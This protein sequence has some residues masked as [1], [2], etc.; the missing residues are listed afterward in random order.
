MKYDCPGELD[1]RRRVCDD[2]DGRFDNLSGSH[3]RSQV[4]CESSVDVKVYGCSPDWSTKPGVKTVI[5][6][7]RSVFC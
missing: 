5:G 1:L 7:F 3:H 6:A 4:N 2:I